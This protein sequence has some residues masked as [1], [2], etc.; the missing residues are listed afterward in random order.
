LND[1]SAILQ[2]MS[3]CIKHNALQLSSRA[4]MYSSLIKRRQLIA[5]ALGVV[6]V[7]AQATTWYVRTNG[8]DSAEGTSWETA[9]G[10]IQAA[11]DLATSNDTIVVTNGVYS[12]INSTSN[13]PICIQSVNGPKVT[14]IDGG[15]TNRC[16][17][18]GVTRG[19][20]TDPVPTNTVLTGFT[21][22]N[23]AKNVS[24]II[25]PEGITVFTLQE[26]GGSS[27]GTL[28]NCI[29]TG[30]SGNRGGGSYF[31][32]LN[33]CI[34]IGNTSLTA[35][36]AAGHCVLNNC[37]LI[38]NM[39]REISGGT[40]CSELNNCISWNNYIRN[41]FLLNEQGSTLRY[42][43]AFPL[44][45]GAGNLAMDPLFT[46]AANGDFRLRTG[47]PCV[48]SGTNA[49]TVGATDINGAN[50]IQSANVDMGACEGVVSGL[51]ISV[52]IQGV[53]SVSPMTAVSPSG[54]SAVF[55]ATSQG[56]PF[57]HFMTNG[58]FASSSTN[59]TWDGI[60]T[61]GVLTAVFEKYTWYVDASRSDNSGDGLSWETAK[62]TIQ[63][64][65]DASLTGDTIMVTNGVYESITTGNKALTVKSVNGRETT[66]IN[67]GGTNRCA[68]LGML[69]H[70]TN[71]ILT[72]FTLCNGF[73]LC[74]GASYGG[75]LDNCTL[76]SNLVTGSWLD[77]ENGG[78][79][80]YFGILNNSVLTANNSGSVGGGSCN[81]RLYNC[82]L[83]GNHAV[84][85]GGSFDGILNNCLLTGNSAIEDGGGACRPDS[86]YFFEG[87]NNC[88][89]ALNSAGNRGGGSYGNQLNNCIVWGNTAGYGS[90]YNYNFEIFR[91]SCTSPFPAFQL[92]AGGNI[93]ADPL[94]VD[95]ANGDFRLQAGSP[96]IN[97]G[98]DE[99]AVG[100]L[101]LDNNP[102][103]YNGRV[104]MGAYEFM[105]TQSTTVPVPFS[106]IDLFYP[107]LTGTNAYETVAGGTG[108]NARPI[109]E[110]Y[111]AGLNPTSPVS[112]FIANIRIS[113]GVELV[114]WAP[115]LRPN[116]VYTV[117]GKTNI[118]DQGW[119]PTNT[120]SRFY[121]V[122]VELPW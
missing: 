61:D 105:M 67:G 24:M 43:C 15:G 95:P 39:A 4:R 69:F 92:D 2:K 48:D 89:L 75:T 5:F 12:S 108:A 100:A 111:V 8:N 97:A 78:G 122:S 85:G 53:G 11:I 20:L 94:F 110:S 104:D 93:S 23:G 87:L 120:A 80:S 66:I 25:Y 21:L 76:V 79:G 116:R 55:T 70:H 52:R 82:K 57:I 63:S 31:G 65:I 112:Q 88:T 30:N 58:V 26:G 36:G 45:D 109:W 71:S 6:A 72:G 29:L 27:C 46:D 34:L 90:T 47:S 42:T 35:G 28:N 83:L 10:T 13:L 3:Q 119:G 17:T 50:R 86:E 40:V 49:F 118:S 9:K 114:T 121:K 54:G 59:F 60:M 73:S 107:G 117:L 115:D 81:G 41:Y 56:R 113:N 51:V 22:R 77:M 16:A 68:T 99:L 91:N 44:S 18:L 38:A 32:T 19:L 64:A 103:I 101:D 84:Q 106:W 1:S 102:R 98:L 62:K 37:T 33:N 7:F 96:C 74:G 14:I